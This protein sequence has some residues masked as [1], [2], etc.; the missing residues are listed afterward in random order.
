MYISL[1]SWT[2][3]VSTKFSASSSAVCGDNEL[4]S[5]QFWTARGF[6]RW[7]WQH[8]NCM[9]LSSGW[10]RILVNKREDGISRKRSARTLWA[11][12]SLYPFSITAYPVLRV[13]GG[14]QECIPSL[15]AK[16]GYTHSPN[17]HPH[18]QLRTINSCQLTKSAHLRTVGGARRELQAQGEHENSTRR[19][20][21]RNP[22][23]TFL[24]RAGGDSHCT[25]VLTRH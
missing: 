5:E 13:V 6:W 25:A 19:G 2:E 20:P 12:M 17:N 16:A 11:S 9:I 1:N 15:R 18:S 23:A 22:S 10:L 14:G 3:N 24:L 4:I 8:D 7:P 21:S